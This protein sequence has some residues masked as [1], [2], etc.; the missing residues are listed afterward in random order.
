MKGE[1]TRAWAHSGSRVSA[2][3]RARTE[4]RQAEHSQL[5]DSLEGLRR[6]MG[7]HGGEGAGQAEDRGTSRK[8]G[9]VARVAT[10]CP[11]PLAADP[12]VS[13]RDAGQQGSPWTTPGEPGRGVLGSGYRSPSQKPRPW[14]MEARR[15]GHGSLLWRS[16]SAGQS[17]PAPLTPCPGQ[18]TCVPLPPPRGGL[19]VHRH[20]LHP[21][22]QQP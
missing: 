21:L 1:L 19:A 5:G 15:A 2:R 17:Q 3:T 8:M 10:K 12:D 9:G 7:E 6:G 20:L 13:E 16:G 22:R 14:L 4:G 11:L 18:P